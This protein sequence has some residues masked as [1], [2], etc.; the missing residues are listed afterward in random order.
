MKAPTTEPTRSRAVQEGG[1]SD[2]VPDI[3]KVAWEVYVIIHHDGGQRSHQ[4]QSGTTGADRT[5]HNGG[6]ARGGGSGNEG[7]GGILL[8]HYVVELGFDESFGSVPLYIDNTSA[9]HISHT[10]SPRAKHI[11]K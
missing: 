4:F 8:Q 1:E 7:G 11:V 6:R 2:R 9:L 3:F 10:Y 5:A